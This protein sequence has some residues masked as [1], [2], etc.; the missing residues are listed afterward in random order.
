MEKVVLYS[1]HCSHCKAVAML[2]DKKHIEYEEHYIDPSK[3]E[4]VQIMLDMGLKSAP[5]LVVGEKV[6]SY[7]EAIQW[8]REQ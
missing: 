4:E 6:M 5:G 2:L 7:T 8:I 1:T 3:P